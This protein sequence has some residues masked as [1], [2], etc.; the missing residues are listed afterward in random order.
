MNFGFWRG[1]SVFITGHTGFKGSWLALWLSRLGA[2]VHGYSLDPPTDPNL[3]TVASVSGDLESHT[4]GDVRDIEGLSSAMRAAQPQIVF[5]LAAQPIVR[6][7]YDKPVETFAVNVLG[8]VNVLEAARHCGS[9]RTIV[10]ITTDKCYE[11]R[12]WVWGYRETDRLGGRDPYSSSKACAELVTAAYRKSFFAERGIQVATARAGN[13]LGGGD[14]GYDRLLPDF[15]RA[16]QSK[17]ALIVRSPD[18]TRPWQHVLEPLC[19]YMHLAA[20]LTEGETGWADAWNFGPNSDDVR[21]VRWVLDFLTKRAPGVQW[22]HSAST[23]FRET[24][25]L[26]LD[27]SKARAKLGW[28]SRWSIETALDRAMSW[29]LHW[30]AGGSMRETCAAQIDE[31]QSVC[32]G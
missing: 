22:R 10:N 16:L 9:V 3:F 14:W 6:A 8:T 29:Y 23:P 11:S 12:E 7:S 5:H 24:S 1:R 26:R 30:L 28:A 21:T 27:S 25:S 13:V 31:Y 32:A 19:G 15:V 18:A 4:I 2:H 20:R 17:D